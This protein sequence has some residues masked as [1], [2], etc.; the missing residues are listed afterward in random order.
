MDGH[1]NWVR[2]IAFSP[3]SRLFASGSDDKKINLWDVEKWELV[4]CFEGHKDGINSIAFSPNGKI[5]ASSAD[6]R[7]IRLW[8][9][10]TGQEIDCLQGHTSKSIESVAFSHDN[11]ILASCSYD[12]TVKLWDLTSETKPILCIHTFEGHTNKVRSISFSPDN[13]TLASSSEDGT[14]KFWDVS[15][16]KQYKNKEYKEIL[17]PKIYQ[18]MNI[19]KVTGLSKSQEYSLKSLGAIEMNK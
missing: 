16:Y 15:L 13:N 9:V 5:L 12:K 2:A 3:D 17:V 14:I 11:Q 4:N 6:D 8:D 7:T 1:Q 18:N 10:K 19:F